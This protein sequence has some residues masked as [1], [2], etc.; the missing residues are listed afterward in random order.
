MHTLRNCNFEVLYTINE[1]VYLSRGARDLII[2]LCKLLEYVSGSYE[3]FHCCSFFVRSRKR[4]KV[5]LKYN[6]SISDVGEF[7]YTN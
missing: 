5:S 4:S 2:A 7:C 3:R 6:N 1:L